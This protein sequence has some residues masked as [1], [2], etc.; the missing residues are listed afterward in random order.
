MDKFKKGDLVIMVLKKG[1]L[2]L[3]TKGK[4]LDNGAKGD[5]VR[6][7]NTNSRQTIEAQVTGPQKVTISNDI[8]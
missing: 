3:T 7:L 8:L 5:M 4:A 6:I 1:A 2:N